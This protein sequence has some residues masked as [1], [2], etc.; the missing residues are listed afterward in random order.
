MTGEVPQWRIG[1]DSNMLQ[2]ASGMYFSSDELHETVHRRVVY[3]NAL[4][5]R[6][7][8]IELPIG[9]LRFSTGHE[10]FNPLVIEAVDRLD[11]LNPDGSESWHIAT[12]GD[13][14]IDDVAYV[15]S[16]ALNVVVT[17]SAET[18]ARVIG[19]R[20]GRGM[21]GSPEHLLR[22]TFDPS[23]FVTDEELED[24]RRVCNQLLKLQRSSFEAAMRA[25]RRIV[26]AS[27]L[28]ADDPTLAFTLYVA[29]LESLSGGQ[30]NVPELG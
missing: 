3:S 13:E 7:D 14:L 24:V 19:H 12:D 27:M 1:E 4:R 29:A 8:D 9:M 23:R 10:R 26:D 21:R 20:G 15:V 2:I 5:V 6:A 16:F 28:V 22:G 25:I 18:A 30:S 11:T 17:S